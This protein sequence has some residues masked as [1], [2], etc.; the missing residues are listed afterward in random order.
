MLI[1]LYEDQIANNWDTIKYAIEESLPPVVGE[2]SDKMNNILESLLIGDTVCW[3]SVDTKKD[4]QVNGV[5]VTRI[6]TDGPSKTKSLLIYCLYFYGKTDTEIWTSGM[7]TL[8]TYGLANGCDRVIGYSEVDAMIRMTER[9]GG[10]SRYRFLS[11][12]LK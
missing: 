7:D 2:S 4:N 11:I 5:V 3:T 6:V 1:R 10:E 9:F 12:P 8:R